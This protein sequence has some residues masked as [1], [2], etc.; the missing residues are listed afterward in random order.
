[1]P[2]R[3]PSFFRRLFGRSR[4]EIDREHDEVRAA[5]ADPRAEGVAPPPGDTPHERYL[6]ELAAFVERTL[7]LPTSPP[8]TKS[9]YGAIIAPL[10]ENALSADLLALRTSS[11]E[12]WRGAIEEE[13]ERLVAES[14]REEIREAADLLGVAVEMLL[15]EGAPDPD[16]A[17]SLAIFVRLA[18]CWRSAELQAFKAEPAKR[19]QVDVVECL[20]PPETNE[21]S[22]LFTTVRE[23]LNRGIAFEYGVVTGSL[24]PDLTRF[25]ITRVALRHYEIASTE[26]DEML[27]WKA[28]TCGL[29][30]RHAEI[31]FEETSS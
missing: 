12:L 28:F 18:Y 8:E 16:L 13:F 23:A 4:P 6:A 3:G 1:M 29:A 27:R 2:E 20:P 19:V 22:I 17:A 11:D 26:I 30:L 25:G 10:P 7:V 24:G 21:A 5:G 31:A 9:R 14:P 15:S